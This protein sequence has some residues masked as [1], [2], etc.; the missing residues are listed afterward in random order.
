[1][2]LGAKQTELVQLM[3]KFVPRSRI[4]IVHNAWTQ[5]TRLDPKL[6]FWCIS[7]C[8]GGFGIVSL[9]HKTWCKTSFTGAIKEKF[10]ELS[11]VGI[12]QNERN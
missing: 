9:L 12:F 2:K 4:G 5:S 6:K 10:R 11:R 7:Q 8:L 1:M 3:Q